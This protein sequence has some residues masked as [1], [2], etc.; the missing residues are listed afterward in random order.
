M[1][2]DAELKRCRWTPR[3]TP[4]AAQ[5]ESRVLTPQAQSVV[6][7]CLAEAGKNGR[8][9]QC[10]RHERLHPIVIPPLHNG[11]GSG[12]RH[13]TG[14]DG[15]ARC[16][17]RVGYGYAINEGGASCLLQHSVGRQIGKPRVAVRKGVG[18]NDR[19]LPC[20][21]SQASNEY[22][23]RGPGGC[24]DLSAFNRHTCLRLENVYRLHLCSV[25][26]ASSGLFRRWEESW[27]RFMSRG[28]LA[29]NLP[30]QSKNC[31]VSHGRLGS[32]CDVRPCCCNGSCLVRRPHTAHAAHASYASGISIPRT[33]CIKRP[34]DPRLYS[35]YQSYVP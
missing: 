6:L 11:K 17:P 5:F 23:I 3:P 1:C 12:R 30:R 13:A 29:Q 26:T 20:L 34:L 33:K 2:C 21:E 19:L 35:S 16:R 32:F 18:T 22:G 25:P 7:L 15:I 8:V 31:N 14:C 9:V 28:R 4:Q 24:T 27:S 10:L